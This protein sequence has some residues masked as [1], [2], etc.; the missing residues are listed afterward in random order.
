MGASIERTGDSVVIAHHHVGLMSRHFFL[1]GTILL[2][3]AYA[4]SSTHS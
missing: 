2:K 1:A 3:P 4:P